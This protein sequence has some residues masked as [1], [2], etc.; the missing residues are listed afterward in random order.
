[1]KNI[2]FPGEDEDEV[3]HVFPKAKPWKKSAE[4]PS[5]PKIL[6]AFGPN[7]QANDS[8]QEAV[9][10]TEKPWVHHTPR[11]HESP[12]LHQRGRQS[13]SLHHRKQVFS[14]PHHPISTPQTNLH[15]CILLNSRVICCCLNT[16]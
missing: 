11:G 9:L 3:E 10:P 7:P 16:F 8:G 15:T 6:H 13:P 12:S 5:A 2:L 1:S 4:L 14:E